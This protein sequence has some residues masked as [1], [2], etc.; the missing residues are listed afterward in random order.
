MSTKESD[1]FKSTLT[2]TLV[3]T[4]DSAT[5]KLPIRINGLADLLGVSTC[6]HSINMHF[7][8]GCHTAEE[9]VPSWTLV[10]QKSVRE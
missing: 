6:A 10:P 3:A 4:Q 9:I 8:L 2:P 1:K 7:I 5:E